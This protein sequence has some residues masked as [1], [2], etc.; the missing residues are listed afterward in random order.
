MPLFLRPR[1][2]LCRLSEKSAESIATRL[3]IFLV[4]R[5]FVFFLFQRFIYHP[6]S[7]LLRELVIQTIAA[8]R[9]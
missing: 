1:W 6:I 2:Q 8:L 9:F 5:L 7:I 3:S 4:R